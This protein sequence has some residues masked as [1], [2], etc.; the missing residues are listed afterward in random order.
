MRYFSAVLFVFFSFYG[1]CQSMGFHIDGNIKNSVLIK[2][3]GGVFVDVVQNQQILVHSVSALNGKYDVLGSV[4]V[5]S[6]FEVVFYKEGFYNKIISFNYSKV[7]PEDFPAGDISPWRN[8][9]IDMIPK[10]V[11]ADLSFLD[12]EPVAKFGNG[13]S[14]ALDVPYEKKMKAKVENAL[15]QAEANKTAN[16]IKYQTALA[17]ADASYKAKKYEEALGKYEEAL[18]YKPKEKYPNDRIQELDALIQAAKKEGLADQQANSEYNNLISA[19]DAFRDQKKYDQAISKYTEALTKKI[20]QYPKDQIVAV[21]KLKK[22]SDNQAKYQDFITAAD[23]SFSQKSYLAAKEKYTLASKL[24]PTEQHPI[25]RLT[26]IEKILNE[27]SADKEKKQKYD[28][29]IAAA[30][31]LFNKGIWLQAKVKYQEAAQYESTATYPIARI[32]ECETQILAI[33]KNK[34]KADKITKLLI[35]GSTLF[36]ASKFADAK[37]K[38]DNV[39]IL[40]PENAEAKLKIAEINKRNSE[41]LDLAEKE[42]TFLKLLSEGDLAVKGLKYTLAK[43][44]YEAALLVKSDV[45]AQAKLDEVT[46]KIKEQ[47]DKEE[48]EIKFQALKIEGMNLAAAQKWQEAKVKLTDANKIRTD[49]LIVTKLKEIES[50]IQSNDASA[51]I[52]Q[53]YAK[54]LA[55]AVSKETSN[56][57]DGAILDYKSASVKKPLEQFPKDKIKELELL[58]INNAR[59]KEIDTK[60]FAVLKKGKESM[61]LFNYLGAI[62]EFNQALLIKP[63]EKEPSDLA[64]EAERLEKEKNNEGDQAYE[65]ILTTAQEKIDQKDYTKARELA[66]RALKGRQTDPRPKDLLKTID[67]LEKQQRDYAAKI[68]EAENLVS[69]NNLQKALVAFEQARLIKSDESLPA[70][71]IDELKKQIAE[72]SA[73]AE[74]ESLYKD[75]MRKGAADMGLKKYE[76]ALSNYQSALSVKEN[77]AIAKDKILEIKQILD[78]LSNAVKTELERKAAKEALLLSANKLFQQ[79]EIVRAKEEY[80]KYLLLDPANSFVKKRIQE[81]EQLQLANEQSIANASYN[82]LIDSAD[83]FFKLKSYDRAKTAYEKAL[84]IRNKD[85]YPK[86]R[87]EEIKTILN[88][89]IVILKSNALQDLGEPTD[90]SII[91]GY[92][93]LVKADMERKNLKNASLTENLEGVSKVHNDLYYQK[94]SSLKLT[95][96]ELASMENAKEEANKNLDENRLKIVT[97]IRTSEKELDIA[98][99]S[100]NTAKTVELIRSQDKINTYVE[101]TEKD[102]INLSVNQSNNATV[103]EAAKARLDDQ[104]DDQNLMETQNSLVTNQTLTAIQVA[105]EQEGIY[106]NENQELLERTVAAYKL[107]NENTQNETQ[108]LKQQE[109]LSNKAAMEKMDIQIAENALIASK[110]AAQNELAFNE[111]ESV[112]ILAASIASD[113]QQEV[114]R[115]NSEKVQEIGRE[116][117]VQNS[118]ANANREATVAILQTKNSEIATAGI[119]AYSKETQEYLK[120]KNTF[121]TQTQSTSTLLETED[122]N[123]L[124]SLTVLETVVQS[125]SSKNSGTALSD[126]D[127]RQNVKIAIEEQSIGNTENLLETLKEKGENDEMVIT[128]NEENIA[129]VATSNLNQQD[130]N[131]KT[132]EKLN[133]VDNSAPVKFKIANTLGQDYP[134]GVSQES[135][136][137][138]DKNGLM[139]AIITR[140]IVVIGGHGDVYVRTQKLQTITYSKNGQAITEHQWQ[141]ETDGAQLE[142]HY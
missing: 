37:S 42:A 60:Y 132:Q 98:S 131:Y 82:L 140:R 66:N 8:A 50:K 101:Q 116:L 52:E 78:D 104:K 31:N 114:S 17:A 121:E 130:N 27:Q 105:V 62:K 100:E 38:Y 68:V 43:E 32:S 135:F 64:A 16:E 127:E 45:A 12:A 75:F 97:K 69:I 33:E 3:E 129:A 111:I 22:A 18:G 119:D 61:A 88:P 48:L 10:S 84:V 30:D 126:E 26:E 93:A 19:A 7:N 103:L 76:L 72:I 142:K 118:I 55:D 49:A 11:A 25:S 141:K 2:A 99:N 1:I 67:N 24:L 112:A 90:N 120:N 134:E 79:N 15:L 4:D 96:D 56:D 74:K 115:N 102:N 70:I 137:Q 113:A 63:N 85:S 109:L 124:N 9:S 87:L 71:R 41:A 73:T 122:E 95:A 28:D 44:K 57:L 40:D 13:A 133:S 128:I 94:A 83:N 89:E 125:A 23:M 123:W 20:E 136:T 106:G 39:L 29:A 6:P 92:A 54:F 46:K 91:D 107:V 117:E 21:E 86:N 53:E 59:Q 34:E 81:C 58:K 80:G 5:S 139:T 14:F 138:K 65:K 108:V 77:D 36:T 51:K 110:I 35:E 47:Q